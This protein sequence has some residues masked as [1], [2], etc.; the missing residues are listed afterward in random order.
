METIIRN[1]IKLNILPKVFSPKVGN[2]V[3]YKD[4]LFRYISYS[5]NGQINNPSFGIENSTQKLSLNKE[6]WKEVRVV[7]YLNNDPEAYMD[8]DKL[9]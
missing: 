2:N 1:G 9:N 8:I 6:Q 5:S 4:K 3:I 7:S